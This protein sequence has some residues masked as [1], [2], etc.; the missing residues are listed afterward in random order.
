M[1]TP[2]PY[3]PAE[4]A[5]PLAPLAELRRPL[6]TPEY[7]HACIGTS[8]HTLD[9][10]R[11]VIVVL[12]GETAGA[13]PGDAAWAD[14]LAIA[15]ARHPGAR[16]RLAGDGLRARWRSDGA[17]PRLRLVPGCT[18]DGMSEQGAEFIGATPLSMRDG[19]GLELVVARGATGT[20][21]ILRVL[22]AFMD[23]IGALHFLADFFRALRGEPLL[24]S[25]VAFSDT[26]LMRRIGGTR[27][28]RG[29]VRPALLT[30]GARGDAHGDSWRRL[31]IEGRQPALLARIAVA[32]A[33]FAGRHDH[34][35]AR[36]AVPVNLRRHL[37]G[38]LCTTNATGMLH[39]DLRAGDT[40]DDF[41]ARLDALLATRAELHCP[42]AVDA[43]RLLPLSWMDRLVSRTA[44]NYTRRR[45]LETVL[46]SSPGRYPATQFSGGG[47][48]ARRMFGIPIP[49]N[50]FIFSYGLDGLS[51][52]TV[53][54]A[55]VH[56]SENRLDDFTGF[57]RDRLG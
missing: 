3:S 8:A 24:G 46:I 12:E 23:G 52:I 35:P 55:N 33:Q 43:L 5:L 4:S 42:R 1:T 19:P 38:M 34:A 57:L 9:G 15:A 18:W 30:G 44:G 28:A 40:V 31:C 45:P 13:V 39:V 50:A 47:F 32:S 56:A 41:R 54:M 26:D 25:N 22:H 29:G 21:V 49:D 2:A 11:E 16:L 48:R 27:P 37:P 53:G 14:A 7:Y 6:S 17:P 10:P 51:D 36:I 20:R